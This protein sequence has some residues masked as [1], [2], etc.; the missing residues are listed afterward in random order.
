MKDWVKAT[1]I[2]VSLIGLAGLGAF[3]GAV[4]S[5]EIFAIFM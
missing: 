5:L 4:L 1:V 3:I 2:A